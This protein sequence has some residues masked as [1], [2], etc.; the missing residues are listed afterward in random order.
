VTR[1]DGHVDKLPPRWSVVFRVG[2]RTPSLLT[3]IELTSVNESNNRIASKGECEPTSMNN[4]RESLL[5]YPNAKKYGDDA[6]Y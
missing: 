1:D 2:R 5:E 4:D 3:C 6:L